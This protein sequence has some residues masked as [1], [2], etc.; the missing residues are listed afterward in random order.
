MSEKIIA[1]AENGQAVTQSMVDKWCEEYD[2]GEFPEGEYSTGRIWY[3][4]S[5]QTLSKTIIFKVSK[6]FKQAVKLRAKQLGVS[7]SD[8][9][10]SAIAD[11]LK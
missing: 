2:K 6:S 3:G 8:F 11:V 4:V 7:M 5:S 10:R 1:I 9:C